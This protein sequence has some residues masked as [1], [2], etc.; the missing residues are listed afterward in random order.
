MRTLLQALVILLLVSQ[1]P[2]GSSERAVPDPALELTATPPR[3]KAPLTVV[4]RGILENVD[5][6]TPPTTASM[7]SG[8]STRTTLST[9]M[10]ALLL[11]ADNKMCS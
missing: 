11:K 6:G 4:L 3:G 1:V 9:P 7:Q 10:T 5:H 2:A 8:T